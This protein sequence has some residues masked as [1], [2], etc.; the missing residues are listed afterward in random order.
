[1]LRRTAYKKRHKNLKEKKTKKLQQWRIMPRTIFNG[2]K[3][4]IKRQIDNE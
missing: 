4:L 2:Q 3:E 1:M